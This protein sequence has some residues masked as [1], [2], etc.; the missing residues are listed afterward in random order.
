MSSFHS[1]VKLRITRLQ[2][3]RDRLKRA[4]EDMLSIRVT[5]SGLQRIWLD[6]AAGLCYM[7]LYQHVMN[8]HTNFLLPT[9]QI[10]VMGAFTDRLD[11]V[12]MFR[13][14]SV[15]IYFVRPI[16]NFK[17]QIIMTTCQ[18]QLPSLSQKPTSHFPDVFAGS[19]DDPNKL[20]A[21]SQF[22]TRFLS[23]YRSPM[24]LLRESPPVVGPSRR[25]SVQGNRRHQQHASHPGTSK[26]K[27]KKNRCAQ[28]QFIY[29]PIY[30]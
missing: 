16:G 22:Y 19:P 27:K 9:D 5:V 26:K 23:S 1:F 8:G 12:E 17:D 30:F 11:V 25:Q 15:P 18:T 6:L 4:R 2:A 3:F 13:E 10:R 14:T 24:A 28:I 20:L 7:K 21:M 29:C